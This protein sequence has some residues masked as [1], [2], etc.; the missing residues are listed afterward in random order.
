MAEPPDGDRS[1]EAPT[2]M[3]ERANCN[4]GEL[5]VLMAIG[6]DLLLVFGSNGCSGA[7]DAAGC[8]AAEKECALFGAC[9]CFDTLSDS[10]RRMNCSAAECRST[11]AI[12]FGAFPGVLSASAPTC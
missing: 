12:V 7:P 6:D 4:D 9:E 11:V 1:G 2:D 8:V 10:D 3:G 5:P